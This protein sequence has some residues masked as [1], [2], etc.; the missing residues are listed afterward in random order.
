M[1]ISC[2]TRIVITCILTAIAFV[3]VLGVFLWLDKLH[4][5]KDCECSADWRRSFLRKFLAF[6]MVILLGNAVYMV[7]HM[8]STSCGRIPKPIWLNVVKAITGFLTI[9][10]VIFAIQYLQK[11]KEK[12][13]DC[14]RSGFGDEM[15]I[16]H[17]SFILTMLGVAVLVIFGTILILPIM[18]ARAVKSTLNGKSR[19]K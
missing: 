14:A 4:K 19:R 15:L 3:L 13:C 17:V 10:Y 11:L 9:L 1:D 12:K 7:Y 6:Y 18:I 5:S 2:K 8:F 16:A